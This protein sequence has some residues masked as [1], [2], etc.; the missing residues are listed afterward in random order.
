MQQRW[1]DTGFSLGS[2]SPRPSA[3][4][5]LEASHVGHLLTNSEWQR[6]WENV[7]DR[8]AYAMGFAPAF[9]T[10]AFLHLSRMFTQAVASGEEDNQPAFSAEGTIRLDDVYHLHCLARSAHDAVV[11]SVGAITQNQRVVLQRCIGLSTVITSLMWLLVHLAFINPVT[12]LSAA[13]TLSQTVYGVGNWSIS[14]CAGSPSHDWQPTVVRL[15]VLNATSWQV[16]LSEAFHHVVENRPEK[17]DENVTQGLGALVVSRF[18]EVALWSRE[19]GRSTR[20][21]EITCE[22]SAWLEVRSKAVRETLGVRTVHLQVGAE[23]P[24]LFGPWWSR[25]L[26]SWLYLYDVFV[27]HAVP[28]HFLQASPEA[29]FRLRAAV[30]TNAFA[31]GVELAEMHDLSSIRPGLVGLWWFLGRFFSVVYSLCLALVCGVLC[32]SFLRRF[33]VLCVRMRVSSQSAVQ[34]LRRHAFIA[35]PLRRLSRFSSR[36]LLELWMAWLTCIAVCVWLY[37][38]TWSGGLLVAVAEYWGLVHVRTKQSRW[39]F[40]RCA[41]VLHSGALL[42]SVHWP[43][44]P[45]WLVLVVLALGQLWLMLALVCHFDCFACLPL[46]PPHSL[47]YRSLVAPAVPLTR[48]SKARRA[49]ATCSA[50]HSSQEAELPLEESSV[51]QRSEALTQRTFRE[52]EGR[53]ID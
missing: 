4:A 34:Q 26:L 31:E 1:S 27:L 6:P 22:D 36:E 13:Q 23:D 38:H 32:S 24:T 25:Q 18:A 48:T 12:Q 50:S 39:I 35:E 46:E 5:H 33:A 40:P 7:R 14:V 44:S 41:A 20:W 45:S 47:L 51:L 42:Y 16:Q 28:I 43:L 21:Y 9:A 19:F 10:D 29:S 8:T 3:L 30:V 15:E 52:N 37:L 11:Q 49:S 53:S 2:G 17:D